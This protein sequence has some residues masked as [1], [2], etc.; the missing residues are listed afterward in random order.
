[1]KCTNYNIAFGSVASL[2]AA[3]HLMVLFYV[4]YAVL[5]WAFRSCWRWT[6]S[7]LPS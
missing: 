1:V 4:L 7:M 3:A 5:H 2:S 6:V